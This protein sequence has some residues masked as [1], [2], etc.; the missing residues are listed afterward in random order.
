MTSRPRLVDIFFKLYAFVIFNCINLFAKDLLAIKILGTQ[1]S[2]IEIHHTYTG[3]L[4]RSYNNF[5][6]S[7]NTSH[8]SVFKSSLF[9]H[10]NL[11]T[12]EIMMTYILCFDHTT[13]CTIID[14][15]DEDD[16][17]QNVNLKITLLKEYIH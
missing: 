15:T 2:W 11:V 5:Y 8:Y 17:F 16:Y 9:Q 13:T 3:N 10:L 12:I 4:F 14:L 7:R 6:H 1:V